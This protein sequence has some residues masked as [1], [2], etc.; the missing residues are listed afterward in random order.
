MTHAFDAAQ[1]TTGPEEWAARRVAHERSGAP[2]RPRALVVEGGGM[3]GAYA[4]GALAGLHATQPWFDATYASSSGA[5]SAA[6]LTAE[7]PAG[8]EIWARHLHGQRLL[9]L[10]NL[11]RGRPLLDLDYLVDEVFARRVPLDLAA[12]RRARAP[13]WVTLTRA[14]DGGVEYRD[15]RRVD[16]PLLHLRAT[17]ALPI[18]HPRPVAIEGEEFVDGG[19]GDPIPIARAIA[20]GADDVTVVLTKPLGYE[21][22]PAPEWV[23]WW[24]TR[25]YPGAREAFRSM[26]ERYN[27]AL[28]LAASPPAGVRVRVVAPSPELHLRRLMTGAR[29]LRAALAAGWG[30][31]VRLAGPA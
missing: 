2:T 10:A 18:A 6:Y 19:L 14:R 28:R 29:H 5:C 26:H 24:G 31:A 20:E 4:A 21:R 7:Q 30:D 8:V 9:R 17:A 15:L 16:D 22:R 13:L 27:A 3:R 25:P 12:L 1:S 23:A 11:A